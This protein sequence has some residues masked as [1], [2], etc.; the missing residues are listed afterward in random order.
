MGVLL[1]HA[2]R[3]S[4]DEI[5][6]IDFLVTIFGGTATAFPHLKF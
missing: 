6:N 5:K 4:A 3:F 1:I 2:S